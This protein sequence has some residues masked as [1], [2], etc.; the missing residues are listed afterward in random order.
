MIAGIA[1]C[2]LMAATVPSACAATSE[3]VTSVRSF[4]KSHAVQRDLLTEST[5]TD[6]ADTAQWG[7]IEDLNVPHTKSQA[8]KD[9]EAAARQAEQA[10]QAEQAR[11]AERE[12]SRAASRSAG[13]SNLS[14]TQTAPQP[15]SETPSSVTAVVNRALA[16]RGSAYRSSGYVWTG[17]P[18]GSAFTC[19]GLVDFALGRPSNS[20]WPESLYAEVGSAMKYSVAELQYGD[21]VFSRYDGR[22]PGHVGIY[23]G[24]G[25]MID[26]APGGVDIRPAATN[27]I[28]GG[29]VL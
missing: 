17:S 23:L 6:V 22:N 26:S 4:P 12:A 25:L 29:P 5:S 3:P 20:S 28:G 9:A 11:Q 19:S 24:N 21:L 18:N 7:G 16:A 1:S 27:F 14:S 15:S 13:R 10:A 2:T 8:E